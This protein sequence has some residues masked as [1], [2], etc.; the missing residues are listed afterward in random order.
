[1]GTSTVSGPFR[2]QNGF[3]ELVNGVWTPVGGG[4]GGLV[5]VAL[6]NQYGGSLGLSDNRYSD[7][8]TQNPPTGPTAGNIIQLP[9]ISVGGTYFI[10]TQVGGSSM[11]AWALQLPT[12][13][14][15]DIS[16]F[17]TGV[18][19]VFDGYT[20]AGPVYTVG[21]NLIGLSTISAPPDTFYVYGSI[22]QASWLGIT[23]ASIGTVAGFGTVAF[24]VQSNTPMMD[25]YTPFPDPF[26]YPYTQLIGS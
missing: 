15:A 4:G 9:P 26:V 14:G 20:G 23:L 10:Y 17:S 8:N 21:P 19:M 7:D 24:F 12:I 16:S 2:S 5:P 18:S 13:P 1:M 3:Q 6:V 22:G 11:D 25:S